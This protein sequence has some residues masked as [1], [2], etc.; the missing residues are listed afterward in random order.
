[1]RQ[2][3]Y[4]YYIFLNHIDNNI[5]K[6]ILKLNNIH[7]IININK[8]N[9]NNLK[10]QF[11]IIEFAKKN[12]IPFL[13]KNSFINCIK[14]KADGIFIESQNKNV[15]KPIMLKKK[16]II[17]G[18]AHNQIEYTQKL[19]QKCSFLMLSPLFYNEKY[20]KNKI[21]SPLKF[22]LISKNWNIKLLALG[23]VFSNNKNKKKLNLIKILGIG[24][25]RFDYL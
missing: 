4:K 13:I 11:S 14:Y 5:K 20:S 7:I 2:L 3:L 18:S 12:K 9:N 6:K 15:L 22:N 21:L 19:K 8:T 16:F 1:M 24:F 25:I 17:I 10:M 23:G